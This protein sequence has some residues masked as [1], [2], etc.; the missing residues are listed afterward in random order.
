[1]MPSFFIAF[2]SRII[3]ERSTEMYSA[4]SARLIGISKNSLL[5]LFLSEALR[6]RTSLVDVGGLASETTLLPCAHT[7]DKQEAYF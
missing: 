6:S 5:D 7:E 2:I 4:S 1:M 3:A